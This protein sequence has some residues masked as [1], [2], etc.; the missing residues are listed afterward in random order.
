MTLQFNYDLRLHNHDNDEM[1]TLNNQNV[2]VVL[3]N[4]HNNLHNND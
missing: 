2:D 4:D 3:Y 1:L